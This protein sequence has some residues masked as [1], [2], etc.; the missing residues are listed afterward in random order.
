MRLGRRT[1][2]PALELLV[3]SAAEMFEDES[4]QQEER[5]ASPAGKKKLRFKNVGHEVM[6]KNQELRNGIAQTQD[7][8]HRFTEL[9]E[10]E[11]LRKYAQ[12]TKKPGY[13]IDPRGAAWKGWCVVQGIIV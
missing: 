3:G 7:L 11:L 8:V 5:V 6:L 10:E 2:Q 13:V 9:N 1:L 12:A 4:Q